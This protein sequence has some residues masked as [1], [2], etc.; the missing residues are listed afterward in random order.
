MGMKK[1]IDH[2]TVEE[3]KTLEKLLMKLE[4]IENEEMK[5]TGQTKDYIEL[6]FILIKIKKIIKKYQ[7]SAW[8]KVKYC[9]IIKVQ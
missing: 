5:K 9:D 2:L 7:K 1:Y 8:Q 6:R 4:P 3:Y